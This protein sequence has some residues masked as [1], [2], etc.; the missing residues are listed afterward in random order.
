MWLFT[1]NA[2]AAVVILLPISLAAAGGCMTKTEQDFIAADC[3]VI[4]L[5]VQQAQP[6]IESYADALESHGKVQQAQQL[7]ADTRALALE[8]QANAAARMEKLSVESQLAD[9][10]RA[11]LRVARALLESY[12]RYKARESATAPTP[13]PP[14]PGVEVSHGDHAE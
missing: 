10:A 3:R 12:D 8:V 9:A 11:S 14:A 13:W 1:K 6:A 2:R 5:Y 4:G 7:R